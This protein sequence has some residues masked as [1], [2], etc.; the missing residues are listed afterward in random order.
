MDD[1]LEKPTSIS[2]PVDSEE[3]ND[4]EESSA[5][6]DQGPDWTKLPSAS[7]ARPVI[8]KR[9][10]KEFEPISAGGSGLQ[11]HVLDRARNAMFDALSA[12]RSIS[13]Y[14]VFLLIRWR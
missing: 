2:Q 5:D 13:R 12:S 10:E 6:E 3:R 14:G 8:P 4:D 9:G 7:A 11:R 1:T